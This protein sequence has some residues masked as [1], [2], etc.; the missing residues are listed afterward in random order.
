[1]D[2][3]RELP[4]KKTS[5][6]VKLLAGCLAVPVAVVVLAL[7]VGTIATLMG[8]EPPP[9]RVVVSRPVVVSQVA[10]PAPVEKTK[11]KRQINTAEF[12]DDWPFTFDNGEL[13]C[14]VVGHTSTG[15]VLGAVYVTGPSGER[16][17]VNGLAR[18]RAAKV[19]PVWR[20]DP[21]PFLREQGIRVS[22]SK[23]ISEGLKLC[24]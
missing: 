3:T 2:K 24:D 1:M 19:E 5:T 15:S 7:V 16:Y 18:T 17:A 11:G 13:K 4:A 9:E 10:E 6:P 12:G 20:F 21:D 23:M 8:Y 14:E 22:I